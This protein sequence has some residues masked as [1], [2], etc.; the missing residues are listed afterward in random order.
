MKVTGHSAPGET[1]FKRERKMAKKLAKKLEPTSAEDLRNTVSEIVTEISGKYGISL[2][3]A[4]AVL[5]TTLR[6][7]C[8]K[9]MMAEQYD[10]LVED[11]L[12]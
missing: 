11:K 2:K 3:D 6:S 9:D 1:N 12:D 5:D 4:R 8:I 10:Y 7:Y